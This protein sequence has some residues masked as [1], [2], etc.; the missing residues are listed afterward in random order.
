VRCK[1]IGFPSGFN[2]EV[3]DSVGVSSQ[4]WEPKDRV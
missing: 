1:L 2:S 3:L 4:E